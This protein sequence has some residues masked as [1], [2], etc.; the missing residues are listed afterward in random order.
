MANRPVFTIS[1]TP[2]YYVEKIIEFKYYSGFAEVQKRKSIESLHQAYLKDNPNQKILEISSKSQE[3][4]GVKLSAFNLMIENK[5][6]KRFSVES[7]FQASKVFENGGPYRELLD[8]TSRE[9]KKYPKLKSS[10]KLKYFNFGDRIFDLIPITYFYNWLYINTLRLYP[11]LT[12]KLMEFD[13]F[14]DIV[15]N[16]DKSINCQARAA[17]VYVSLRKLNLLD[18]ALLDKNTFLE[19]VYGNTKNYKV[20][21]LKQLSI[22]D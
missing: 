20:D 13:A 2:P 22:W 18:K 12:N 14:T 11:D 16:P 6:G 15:F 1:D 5:N 7:A 21:T 10:G 8:M 9:A 4:L 19:N 3:E 17:A